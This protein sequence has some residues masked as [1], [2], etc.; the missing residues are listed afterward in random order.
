VNISENIGCGL[1][2]GRS[3]SPRGAEDTRNSAQPLCISVHPVNTVF[4]FW[5]PRFSEATAEMLER[6]FY[7]IWWSQQGGFGKKIQ[8]MGSEKNL[9]AQD[10]ELTNMR[11][12]IVYI[13][14]V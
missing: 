8:H 7:I 14:H 9:R 11:G 12:N 10:R 4:I 5:L 3:H 2:V 13:H 1:E 6:Y